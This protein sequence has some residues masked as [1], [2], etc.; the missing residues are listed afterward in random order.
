MALSMPGYERAHEFAHGVQLQRSVRVGDSYQAALPNGRQSFASDGLS[1]NSRLDRLL[2][3][4]FWH[5]SETV[6]MPGWR[7]HCPHLLSVER[8]TRK[9]FPHPHRLASMRSLAATT[10]DLNASSRRYVPPQ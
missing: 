4:C 2:V 5:S 3:W 6:K 7:G 1:M 9:K 10:A 8:Q